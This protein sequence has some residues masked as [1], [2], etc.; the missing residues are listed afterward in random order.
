MNDVLCGGF[1]TGTVD[2]LPPDSIAAD[3]NAMISN[4]R[5]DVDEKKIPCNP[6][7]CFDL[8]AARGLRGGRGRCACH[9]SCLTAAERHAIPSCLDADDTS[10]VEWAEVKKELEDHELLDYDTML[11]DSHT[12]LDDWDFAKSPWVCKRDLCGVTF[13]SKEEYHVQRAIVFIERKDKSDTGKKAAAL[14]GTRHLKF[15][16]SN[17]AEFNPPLTLLDMLRVIIDPLHAGLLNLPKTI[18]K[19]AFGDR[20]TNEQRELLAEYLIS[21]DCP[22]DVRAKGDGRDANHKWFMGDV[23]IR[24]VEGGGEDEQPRLDRKHQRDP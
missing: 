7:G 21:I 19:Y 23:F 1:Y 5:L 24:F 22:L 13:K 8:A 16:P 14:R 17:Q 2:H 4:Q 10:K 12:P 11:N 18:W 20:M 9:C 3:F 6:I 15:H